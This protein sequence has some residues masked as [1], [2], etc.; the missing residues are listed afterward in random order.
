MFRMRKKCDQT[1]FDH[2]FIVGAQR[3]GSGI[4]E[5]TDGLGFSCTA[6]LRIVRKIK[7][8]SS[9]CNF[10]LLWMKKPC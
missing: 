7:E 1:D 4:S 6:F 5:T 8:T 2:G 10:A 9:E 3:D